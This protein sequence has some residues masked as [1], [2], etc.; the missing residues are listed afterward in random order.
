MTSLSG[1]RFAKLASL[2]RIVVT[3]TGNGN[4]AVANRGAI[5]RAA[6]SS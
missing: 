6:L 5:P 3:V 4:S 1:W 2:H